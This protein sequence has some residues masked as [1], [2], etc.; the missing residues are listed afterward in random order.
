MTPACSKCA[1]PEEKRVIFFNGSDCPG[2][3]CSCRACPKSGAAVRESAAAWAK[4]AREKFPLP[5]KVKNTSMNKK[6]VIFFM[7]H[8]S[9]V[10]T[11]KLSHILS[12]IIDENNKARNRGAHC[13]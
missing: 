10:F 2:W 12:H 11:V 9:P 6:A 7:E 13:P 5:V 3:P 4:T 8:S 1:T